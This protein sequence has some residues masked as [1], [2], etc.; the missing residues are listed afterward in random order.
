MTEKFLK[1]IPHVLRHEGGYNDI[2]EDMG[3]A[4][5]YGISLRFLKGSKIDVNKDGKVDKADIKSLN[6]N[7]AMQIYYDN[8]WKPIYDKLTDRLSIKV[9]DMA[10]NM[11]TTQAH[12]L[13]QRAINAMGSAKVSVDGL[14]GTQTLAE[15][16]KLD[17]SSLLINICKEQGAFYRRIIKNNPKQA[18]FANG[19]TYRANWLP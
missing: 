18:K 7:Q 8:F 10:V 5:N 14:I 9:F 11:G 3:G 15:I 4:T 19:W 13:L 1:A 17:E 12:I 6:A 2:R 16:A